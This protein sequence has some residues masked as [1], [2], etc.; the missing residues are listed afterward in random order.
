MSLG[1]ECETQPLWTAVTVP[2]N[3]LQ[4]DCT[5]RRVELKGSAW[6]NGLCFGA[7]R[8]GRGITYK[9]KC[10]Q[11]QPKGKQLKTALKGVNFKS[12]H[13]PTEAML[14]CW[15]VLLQE[16]SELQ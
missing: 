1:K 2:Y 12:N 15:S 14:V 7:L 10:D 13:S 6:L 4:M 11:L 8:G 16:S 5:G 9:N 3:N